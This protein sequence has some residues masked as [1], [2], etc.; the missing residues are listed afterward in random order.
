MRTTDVDDHIWTTDVDDRCRW[1]DER[2]MKQMSD[3]LDERFAYC[4]YFVCIV[5]MSFVC[6]MLMT[7]F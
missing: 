4:R 2:V 3:V 1:D 5:F 7:L 6:F